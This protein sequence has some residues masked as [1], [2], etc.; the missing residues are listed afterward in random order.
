MIRHKF[1][2]NNPREREAYYAYRRA[3]LIFIIIGLVLMIIA[4]LTPTP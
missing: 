1:N 3:Q 4:A 2:M